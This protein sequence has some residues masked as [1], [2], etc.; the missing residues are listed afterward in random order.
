MSTRIITDEQFSEGTAIDGSAISQAV[1]DVVDRWNN[2]PVGDLRSRHIQ[3]QIVWGYSPPPSALSPVADHIL[4]WAHTH[5]DSGDVYSGSADDITNPQ[6]AKGYEVE[7][8]R[9]IG[10]PAYGDHFC[11]ETSLVFHKP[12]ILDDWTVFLQTDNTGASSRPFTNSFDWNNT[13]I[14]STEPGGKSRDLTLEI[15]IDYPFSPEDRKQATQVLLRNNFELDSSQISYAQWVNASFSDMTPAFPGGSLTGLCV[16]LTN[17]RVPVP[18]DA[19][20]R[21]RIIIPEYSLAAPYDYSSPW[22]AAPVGRQA[23]SSTLTVMQEVT[24]G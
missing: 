24:R 12:V 13:N 7:G 21:C 6:R 10:D 18:R 20:V 17:L 16:R 8:I 19:R 22:G 15:S 14:P 9:E 23:Y 5:N 1:R 3:Q 11:W 2:V 4:P